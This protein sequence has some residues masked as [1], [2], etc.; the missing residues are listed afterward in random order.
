MHSQRGFTFVEI[1]IALALALPVG[2]ALLGITGAGIRAAAAAAANAA[3]SRTM[4]ETVERL[5]AESHSAAAIFTP[6]N[7]LFGGANC[8]AEGDCR[9]VDFF[10][11]DKHGAAHFWAYRYDAAAQSLQRYAYDDLSAGGPVNLRASGVSL[12]GLTSF[13][14]RRIPISQIGIPALPGYVARDV[15]VPF[16]YPGVAGGNAIVAVDLRNAALALHHELLPRL[17]AT[18]FT[19]VV[20]TYAPQPVATSAPVTSASGEL[21]PYVSSVAWRIGPCVNVPLRQPGC[22]GADDSGLLAEQDGAD[23]G[24]GGMLVAPADSKISVAGACSA[25]LE[26]ARDK[27]GNVYLRVTVA[28]LGAGELWLV[29]AGSDYVPPV[30]PLRPDSGPFATGVKA[31]PGYEYITTYGFAC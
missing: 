10:T 24:P 4:L 15:S 19:I 7:D 21:R 16:G 23:A 18:G 5:D 12:S 1:L 11:R 9:E 27:A 28:A 31:G 13:S 17:T 8:T 3:A 20:G 25:Q 14:A 6:P 30:P 26:G 29:S 22:G 2:F